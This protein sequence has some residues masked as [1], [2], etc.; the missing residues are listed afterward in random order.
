[1]KHGDTVIGTYRYRVLALSALDVDTLVDAPAHQAGLLALVPLAA[2]ATQAHV[3][4][5]ARRLR[6]LDSADAPD[7]AIISLMLGSRT[8][9]YDELVRIFREDFLMLG[10]GWAYIER[11]GFEKGRE[12]GIAEGIE[13]G[14]E[15]GIEQGIEQGIERGRHEA[16]RTALRTVSAARFGNGL[17]DLLDR[18]PDAALTEALAHVATAADVDAARAAL[19]R[20]DDA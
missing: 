16:A 15:R 8:F 5:A 11:K 17:D 12:R 19:K 7:L 4:Q 10:D 14:V 3:A 13:Q 2:G 6:S 18:V 9:G 20:P 1:M